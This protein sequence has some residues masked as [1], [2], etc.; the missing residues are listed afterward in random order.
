MNGDDTRGS[1]S[2]RV[3]GVVVGLVEAVTGDPEELGRIRV[4]LPWLQG[5]TL[6]AWCRVASV[7]AGPERG[8]FFQPHPQDEVLVAFE[9]GDLAAPYVVGALW[10]GVDQPPVPA[11]KRQEV[12]VIK[13]KGGAVIRL[14]DSASTIE[15]VDANGSRVLLDS[16]QGSIS[17][18]AKVGTPPDGE[19]G[20]GE[21]DGSAGGGGGESPSIELLAETNTV[22][23]SAASIVLEAQTS[24]A[25]SSTG[26]V[27][28]SAEGV[29]SVGGSELELNPP[30]G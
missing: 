14:D 26:T 17:L 4:R 28:I 20:G 7:A 21:G 29:T 11:E 12:S 3:A 1:R 27:E 19:A 18:S 10:N 9:H 5:D 23:I 25:A 24:L 16:K 2:P 30:G 15:I 8:V 22:K 6:S 13:T